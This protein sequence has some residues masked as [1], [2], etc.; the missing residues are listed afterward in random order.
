VAECTDGEGGQLKS[1]GLFKDIPSK[2]SPHPTEVNF[3]LSNDIED[4]K[5]ITRGC[6]NKYNGNTKSLFSQK[7]RKKTQAFFGEQI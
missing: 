4:I 2:D 6:I 7:I 5:L 1:L 3:R